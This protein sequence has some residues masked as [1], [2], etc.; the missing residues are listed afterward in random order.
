LIEANLP[1][2]IKLARQSVS[3]SVS[4]L[5]VDSFDYI[6]KRWAS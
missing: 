2:I 4:L 6:R 3:Q 5:V 1:S